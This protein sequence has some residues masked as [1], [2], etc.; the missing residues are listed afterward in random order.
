M[1]QVYLSHGLESGPDALKVQA[2][3]GVV[4]TRDDCEAVLMDYRDQPHVAARLGHLLATL[5]TRGDDPARCIMAGSSLG[6]FL[7]AA[8]SQR[9]PV[10]GCFLLAPALGMPDY[11]ETTVTLQARH[12]H[13]VHGWGDDVVPCGPVIEHARRQRLSLRLVDDDHRLHASLEVILR[14]FEAFLDRCQGGHLRR[15]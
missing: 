11:P 3:K 9:H 7:S 10:L 15:T 6:G 12:T 8:V 1:T 2:L 13:I 14:D 5:E 4:E